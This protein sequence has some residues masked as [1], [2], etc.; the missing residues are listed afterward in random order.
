MFRRFKTT[1]MKIFSSLLIA[2]LFGLLSS[3]SPVDTMGGG[4]ND[5]LAA[6]RSSQM[7]ASLPSNTADPNQGGFWDGD[8][9]P[10]SPSIR[11][12][13]AQQKAYFYKGNQLVGV[14]PISSGDSTHTTPAGTFRVTQKSIAHKSSLYG[15]IKNRY[16]GQIVNE[17]GDTRLHQAGPDEVFVNAPMP[18]FLRFNGAIGMHGGFL[19]GYPASHGCVRLPHH[20]AEIYFHNAPA[21]TPVIVE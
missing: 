19:P 14:T 16:T 5:Y 17:E 20:M 1:Q 18:F 12:N 21:G 7:P 10:G 8:G 2:A 4:P 11:I 15:V 6:Y 3:C 9:V 13:R